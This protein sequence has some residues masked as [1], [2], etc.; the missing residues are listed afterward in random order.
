MGNVMLSRR[1][2]DLVQL[3][4]GDIDQVVA[5]LTPGAIREFDEI[6][7]VDPRIALERALGFP[8][9]FAVRKDGKALAATGVMEISNGDPAHSSGQMWTIF[10]NGLN[11]HWMSFA[12]ASH[13]LVSIYNGVYPMLHCVTDKREDGI[14][15]WLGHLGFSPRSIEVHPSGHEVVRFVRCNFAKSGF[16]MEPLRPA[17]H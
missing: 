8:F 7:R 14:H 15:H 3:E 6:Q 2:L 11:R 17:A 5:D 10:T 4:Q 16:A 9:V 1:G 13:S 12:R